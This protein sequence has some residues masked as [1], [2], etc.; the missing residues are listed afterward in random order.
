[1]VF[2]KWFNTNE[3]ECCMN[4]SKEVLSFLKKNYGEKIYSMA[5]DLSEG[6]K[7]ATG[8]FPLDFCLGGGIPKGKITQIYGP[9]D[10]AK[11]TLSLGIIGHLQKQGLKCFHIDVENTFDKSWAEKLGVDLSTLI[12]LQPSNGE[13]IVDICDGLL[14][15]DDIDFGV[16]DS[17]GAIITTNE[18]E[19]YGDK[20]IVSGNS[21]VITKILRKSIHAQMEQQKKGLFP[22]LFCVNQIRQKI[23]VMYGNPEYFPGGE[24]AQHAPSLILRLSGKPIL[25]KQYNANIPTKHHVNV[26]VRKSKM[27]TLLNHIEFE[28]GLDTIGDLQTGKSNDSELMVKYLKSFNLLNKNGQKYYYGDHSFVSQKE[29]KEQL[30]SDTTLRTFTQQYLIDYGRNN[31][32]DIKGEKEPF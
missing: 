23:G 25:D 11:S 24:L 12:V 28:I 13:Q 5:E 4:N 26:S 2:I 32:I 1:M 14:N 19:S 30:D 10:S 27:K 15:C 16:I 21:G 18:V 7:L 9:K 29:L 8:I 17:L 3:Y 22:T 6:D 20:Q 31:L